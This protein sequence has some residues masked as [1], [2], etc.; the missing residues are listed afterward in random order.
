MAS[1][2]NSRVIAGLVLRV[3]D[4]VTSAVVL[5]KTADR[6]FVDDVC[7]YGL[8]DSIKGNP[9]ACKLAI[10]AGAVTLALCVIFSI[11]AVINAVRDADSKT[12]HLAEFILMT[13][14]E[15]L[16]I[17]TVGFLIYQLVDK[18][19]EIYKED[20]DLE[21][22]AIIVIVFS[23]LS[24]GFTGALAGLQRSAYAREDV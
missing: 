13:I 9:V 3:L 20:D 5:G 23:A 17:G 7:Y 10:A 19:S 14:L 11:L 16:W 24:T 8:G 18:T 21:T 4:V 22:D 12:A 15:L 1:G 2:F 6:L